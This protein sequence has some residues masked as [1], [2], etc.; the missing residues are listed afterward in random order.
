MATKFEEIAVV[1]DQK[2]IAKDIYDLTIQTKEIA[3]AAKA[4]Q[5]ISL[6]TEM[7]VCEKCIA[8]IKKL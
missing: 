5:F 1:V 8:K 6:Y 4:G 2:P 3:A 7:L